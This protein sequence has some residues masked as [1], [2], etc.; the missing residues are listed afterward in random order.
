MDRRGGREVAAGT[1]RGGSITIGEHR[2]KLQCINFQ[3]EMFHLG[4][5]LYFLQAAGQVFFFSV[6]MC[7]NGANKF[8]D[9]VM[10]GAKKLGMYMALKIY[11]DSTP[12]ELHLHVHTHNH[13]EKSFVGE[14]FRLL[15]CESEI[16]QLKTNYEAAGGAKKKRLFG[17]GSEAGNYFGKK[18]CACNAS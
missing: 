10:N 13:D 16:D 9:C 14:R 4:L 18:F 3:V 1:H 8:D 6:A 11:R 7:P 12:S 2:K 5:L 15:H 17:L